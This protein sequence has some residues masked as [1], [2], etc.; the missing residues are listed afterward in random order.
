MPGGPILRSDRATVT[1]TL[2]RW[3][4]DPDRWRRRTAV[5][6]QVGAKQDTDR[7]LLASAVEATI[8][9]SDFFLRKGIGRAL[10]DYARTAPD[11]VRGSSPT[12][13]TCPDCPHGRH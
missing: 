12:I 4:G 2:R 3:V 13:R 9:D 1:T 7:A 8:G 11:W 5:I 10:R 6:C